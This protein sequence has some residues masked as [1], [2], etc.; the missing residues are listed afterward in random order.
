M[1]SK[2]ALWMLI[3]TLA[4]VMLFMREGSTIDEIEK[5][6][7]D[8]IRRTAQ[9]IQG[10]EPAPAPSFAPGAPMIGPVAGIDN[11][12]NEDGE[13]PPS[14]TV[15]EP[16][17]PAFETYSPAPSPANGASPVAR[18]S[19]TPTD[20]TLEDLAGKPFDPRLN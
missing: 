9:V 1:N 2:N 8:R 13:A 11:D 7:P 20:T 15:P 12:D 18:P 17:G 16:Q 10:R 14:P 19:R 6:D 4:F 5:S 3:G